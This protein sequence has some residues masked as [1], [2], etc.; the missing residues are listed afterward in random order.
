ME[1]FH[2]VPLLLQ[3]QYVVIG[4]AVA[5]GALTIKTNEFPATAAAEAL[6][7][8]VWLTTQVFH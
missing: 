4:A 1:Q 7:D 3:S 8:A 2:T 5:L 6:Q